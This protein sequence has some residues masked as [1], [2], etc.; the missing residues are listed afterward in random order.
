MQLGLIEPNANG[1]GFRLV[2][3]AAAKNSPESGESVSAKKVEDAPPADPDEVLTQ[4][5]LAGVKGTSAAADATLALVRDNAP[6]QFEGVLAAIGADLSPDWSEIAR[7]VGDENVLQAGPAMH[8]EYLAAGRQVLK[9]TAGL[10]ESQMDGFTAWA[11]SE[12]PGLAKDAVREFVENH[13]PAKLAALGRKYARTLQTP[14]GKLKAEEAAAASYTADEIM[15]A[16]FG[17]GIRAFKSGNGEAVLDIPG[18]GKH[19]F[20]DAVRLGYIR[21]TKV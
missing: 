16:N 4:A 18:K 9:S 7:Q 15:A 2:S 20:K 19:S 1:A 10:D 14:V 5:D 13:N 12:S 6:A 3:G 17:G 11:V 21:V 8:Q